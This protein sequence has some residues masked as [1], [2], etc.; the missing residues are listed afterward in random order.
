MASSLEHAR[1]H[2]A[3]TAGGGQQDGRDA[4]LAVQRDSHVR[5]ALCYC[6]PRPRRRARLAV[7]LVARHRLV[8]L[9][10]DFLQLVSRFAQG[11]SIY[12]SVVSACRR[13]CGYRERDR[14]TLPLQWYF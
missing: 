9:G 3:S 1:S 10:S 7:L 2:L 4:V 13:A 11:T 8:P 14:L 5:D 6:R 12:N